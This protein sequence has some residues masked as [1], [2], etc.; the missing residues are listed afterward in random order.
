VKAGTARPFDDVS[1]AADVR[2]TI[3]SNIRRLRKARG[4]S[5]EEA[6]RRLAAHGLAWSNVVWCAAE[7]SADRDDRIRSFTAEEIVAL[8]SLF[9]VTP[10][11]LFG[12]PEIVT[13]PRCDGSGRVVRLRQTTDQ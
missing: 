11:E 2:R 6:E 8:A 9:E 3:A 5:Q 7:K 10:N 13:C 12:T 1:G 4:W